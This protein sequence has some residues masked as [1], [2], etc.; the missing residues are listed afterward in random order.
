V[1]KAAGGCTGGSG[2]EGERSTDDLSLS[3]E[4]QKKR[5]WAQGAPAAHGGRE[6]ARGREGSGAAPR[7]FHSLGCEE[8]GPRWRP[9]SAAA[10]MVQRMGGGGR[11]M[12]G[13]TGAGG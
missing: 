13:C 9:S 4:H 2:S 1:G 8:P 10:A 5:R 7:G 12:G 3:V 11:S 6:A